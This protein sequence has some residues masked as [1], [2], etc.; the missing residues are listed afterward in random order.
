[1]S[2]QPKKLMWI[3]S[4]KKDL[5][6]MPDDV[7]DVFGF[8][9]HLAQIGKK[10]DKAKPLKGFGGA[11]VLEV[12]ERDNDGTYRAVYTVKYGDAVY[13]LHCFQK[14]SSKGIA[15]P[16]PEMNIINERLKAAKEHAE[17]GPPC[18]RSC[19]VGDFA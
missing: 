2:P 8:A 3:G 7:R 10:H 13:V 4:T 6:A 12:V 19:P 5:V 15:T 17:G 1:M 18:H 11:G 16:K 14:K 9:L